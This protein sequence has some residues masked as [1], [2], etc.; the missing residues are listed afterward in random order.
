MSCA[1]ACIPPTSGPLCRHPRS[2]ILLKGAP[3]ELEGGKGLAKR[4]AR[5][6]TQS[7]IRLLTRGTTSSCIRLLARSSPVHQA[8]SSHQNGCDSLHHHHHHHHCPWC[9]SSPLPQPLLLQALCVS[10]S[11]APANVPRA[12]VA[13]LEAAGVLRSSLAGLQL[14][15]GRMLMSAR[16]K[17]WWMTPEWRTSTLSIPPETQF[18]LVRGAGRS[19]GSRMQLVGL[20]AGSARGGGE[21]GCAHLGT[22]MQEGA[23]GGPTRGMSHDGGAGRSSL[24]VLEDAQVP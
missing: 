1:R 4:S 21:G 6:T 8:L 7:P 11:C 16:C 19:L 13:P 15:A 18:L 22:G 9:R 23:E 24:L 3:A 5:G 10:C 12:I 20:G 2:V 14:C 17:L